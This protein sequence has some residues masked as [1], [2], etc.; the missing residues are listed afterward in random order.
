MYH[1]PKSLS[2]SCLWVKLCSEFLCSQTDQLLLCY[3]CSALT[4]QPPCE[5]SKCLVC[6][7]CETAYPLFNWSSPVHIAALSDKRWFLTCLFKISPRCCWTDI[8]ILLMLWK[9]CST[10]QKFICWLGVFFSL[11]SFSGFQ[12][13]QHALT[14]SCWHMWCVNVTKSWHW[15]YL[16]N[17]EIVWETALQ[18]L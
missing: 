2:L 15:N 14:C 16:L 1:G 4:Q 7:C 11:F 18:V 8:S 6:L 12:T 10:N 9:Y 13:H 17:N 5:F 3:R